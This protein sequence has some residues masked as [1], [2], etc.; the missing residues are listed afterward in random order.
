MRL[1]E[2]AE[3]KAELEAAAARLPG[4]GSSGAANALSGRFDSL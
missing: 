1:K 4:P 3:T 2:A